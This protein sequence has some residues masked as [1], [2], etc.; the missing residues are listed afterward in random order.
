MRDSLGTGHEHAGVV[1]HLLTRSSSV[2]EEVRDH[3]GNAHSAQH[4]NDDLVSLPE[5]FVR[6]FSNGV[7]DPDGDTEE[8]EDTERSKDI[9]IIV[10]LGPFQHVQLGVLLRAGLHISNPIQPSLNDGM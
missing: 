3:R 1:R 10:D 6:L 5:L 9:D 2:V 7:G 4:A 8:R